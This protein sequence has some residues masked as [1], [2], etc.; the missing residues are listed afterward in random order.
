ME[1]IGARSTCFGL[2]GVKGQQRPY[3]SRLL[4]T[5]STLPEDEVRTEEAA[6]LLS[7]RLVT[8]LQIIQYLD[9]ALQEAYKIGQKPVSAEMI[10]S[11]L[12]R[13]INGLESTLTRQGYRFKVVA[14]LLNVRPVDIRAF[15]Q[16]QLTANRAQE[17][18]EERLVAGI[19]L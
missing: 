9:L 18:R 11:V 17:L 1:E 12:A 5:C 3:I 8:P 6:E 2:E 4:E 13:D 14:D 15:L 10:A 19:P 7:A 16:G